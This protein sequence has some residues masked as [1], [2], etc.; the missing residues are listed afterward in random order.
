MKL[1]WLTGFVVIVQSTLSSLSVGIEDDESNIAANIPKKVIERRHTD[2]T[3]F[4]LS[5]LTT[6]MKGE[7]QMVIKPKAIKMYR[8]LFRTASL[9]VCFAITRACF[10]DLGMIK[11]VLF[12][13]YT[14]I[15]LFNKVNGNRFCFCLNHRSIYSQRISFVPVLFSRT[16]FQGYLRDF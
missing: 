7:Q 12:Y 1:Y 13:C 3:I 10:I 4:I 6:G 15:A 16:D 11:L 5:P 14:S 8:I 9:K 2:S